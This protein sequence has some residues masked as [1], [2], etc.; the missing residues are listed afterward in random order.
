MLEVNAKI[1]VRDVASRDGCFGVNG[2][3]YS[4]QWLQTQLLLVEILQTNQQNNN[5]I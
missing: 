2:I 5:Y 4:Q 3:L 1:E